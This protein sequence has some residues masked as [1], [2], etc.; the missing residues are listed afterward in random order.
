MPEGRRQQMN[1]DE[2][3]KWLEELAVGSS[4]LDF[5]EECNEALAA[6]VPH[7][8][9]VMATILK[10]TDDIVTATA[11]LRNLLRKHGDETAEVAELR[12][13]NDAAW[14]I[15]ACFMQDKQKP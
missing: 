14:G 9:E 6:L 10:L 1:R 12:T 15:A 13:I 5:E 4:S 8:E 11:R 2:A 7:N 3:L